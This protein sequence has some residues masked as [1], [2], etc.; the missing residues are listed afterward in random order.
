MTYEIRNILV[1]TDFSETANNALRVAVGMAMRQHANIY[2]MHVVESANV[3]ITPDG[4][5]LLGTLEMPDLDKAADLLRKQQQQISVT[6]KDLPVKTV[7]DTG[8]VSNCINKC[9]QENDVNLVIMG[10]HGSSGVKDYFMGANTYEVIKQ[11]A[12]PV[13]SIPASFDE[14]GFSSI[15]YPVR[16]VEGVVEK[17]DYIKPIVEQNDASLHILGVSHEVEMEDLFL[18][19]KKVEAVIEAIPHDKNYITCEIIN[20][21]D[22]AQKILEVAE[23]RMDDLMIINATLDKKW[24]QFFKGT[25][26][27]KIVNHSKIP[28]LSV[29]PELTPDLIKTVSQRFASE[30]NYFPLNLQPSM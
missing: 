1:P 22:I 20:C 14:V 27:Q 29:K 23:K 13:L 6:N 7:L 15:L 9:I 2:L 19:S 30:P 17:Y 3:G 16:N 28:V 8:S 24:Y 12:C 11:A 21:W 26:T 18:L 25:F 10:S 4:Y 5:G